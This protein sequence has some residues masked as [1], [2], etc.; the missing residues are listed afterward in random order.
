MPTSLRGLEIRPDTREYQ[1]VARVVAAVEH[2]TGRASTWN[3]RPYDEHSGI[4][5][6]AEYNGPMTISRYQVLDPVMEAY[7]ASGPPDLQTRGAAH[8]GAMVVVHETD[9]HQH[10]AGDEDAPDAVGRFSEECVAV[11]EGL[12]D[13]NAARLTDP[14]IR[15]IGMDKAVPGSDTVGVQMPYANPPRM[16]M[17]AQ[18]RA[19]VQRIE[20]FYG[21]PSIDLETAHL[22]QF[23]D[24]GAQSGRG[25][26]GAGAGAAATQP[27][28]PWRAASPRDTGGAAR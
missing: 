19:Q 20:A 17:S 12:S 16:P 1:W 13:S 4:A 26:G 6:S 18:Q 2:R 28:Q 22:R 3:R 14:I 8:I 9:H 24:T 23:L 25:S 21:R 11:R 27:T 15:D 5:A 10:E 7:D